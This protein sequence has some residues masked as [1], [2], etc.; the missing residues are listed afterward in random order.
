PALDI[1]T[2][3]ARTF[4]DDD[5]RWFASVT[6]DVNPIH[7][8]AGWA[9]VHFPGALVVHGQHV[10]LWALDELV[11]KRPGTR[12]ASIQ[13]TFV[14]PIVVGD[15]VEALLSADHELTQIKV[16]DEI[17]VAVRVEFGSHAAQTEPRF[18][19]GVVPAAARA[20]KAVE[21]GGVSG[22]VTL[23]PLAHSLT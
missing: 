9:A 18:Q 16:H 19:G 11:R 12:L 3:F 20:R 1:M 8:D 22:S 2:V 10:L 4:D 14:K 15:R 23:P 21:L 17:A 7:V 13:A 6:G 5:Q